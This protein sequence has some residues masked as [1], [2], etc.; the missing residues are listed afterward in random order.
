MPA[1]PNRTLV[2]RGPA[3]VKIGSALFFTSKDIVLDWGIANNKVDSSAFG[4]VFPYRQAIKPTLKVP[5]VGEI[6][7]LAV[8]FPN[9]T[10]ING[11]SIF[12]STDTP[13]EIIP[14]DTTQQKT[15]FKN[16]AIFNEPD[17]TLGVSGGIALGD[18]TLRFLPALGVPLT[19]PAAWFTKATND[20]DGTGF[21]PSTILVRSYDISWLSA[22][23][24]TLTYGAN[25]TASLLYN[26]TASS[27]ATALTALASITSA[28]GVTVA[29]DYK[30]G[31]TVTFVSS[32]VATAISGTVTGMPGGTAVK[33][34]LRTVGA[35][36][37][38]QVALL[39][40]FPWAFFP[41]ETAVK[42][43]FNTKLTDQ[44]SD[45]I[46]VYDIVFSSTDAV[47]TFLP[48]N[49]SDDVMNAAANVQGANA[50]LGANV[51]SA[52]HHL[53]FGTSGFYIRLY[54]ATITKAGL[55]WSADKQRVPQLEWTASRTISGGSVNPI[56][57]VG[58]TAPV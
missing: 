52:A 57:S 54:S 42:V 10:R 22:G 24:Y 50:A 56:Y 46:G 45:A 25:T 9:G 48:L 36:G 49:V 6:K 16:G 53:D 35:T 43:K 7:N 34:T 31:F 18:T 1:I 20:W 44:N 26:A 12:S 28:G 51:S 21:D 3:F 38:A 33:Q 15:I 17:L 8:L 40:L 39:Q 32:G 4:P 41:T 2:S 14:I 11:Q 58:T 47:A 27:V 55:V 29:G 19:D 23:T 5:L 37:V 13:V 30:N